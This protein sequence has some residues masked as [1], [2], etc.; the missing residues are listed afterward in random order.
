MAGIGEVARCGPRCS[1]VDREKMEKKAD[2][3]SLE[4]DVR[5]HTELRCMGPFLGR[6]KNG[7]E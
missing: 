2:P 6:T 7:G 5:D 1:E 4:W 3:L